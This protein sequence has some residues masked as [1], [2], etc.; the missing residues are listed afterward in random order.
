MKW[1]TRERPKI[2]RIACPWLVTRFID[3]EAEFI[4][5]PKDKVMT[6]AERLGAIPFDV[7]GVEL[8][9]HGPL[10]SFDAFIKKYGLNDPALDRLALIVRGADTGAPDL[11]PEVA[12]LVA[13]SWGLNYNYQD[14]HELLAQ[15]MVMYDALYAWCSRSPSQNA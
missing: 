3:P 10:C 6:E 4:Y 8:G 1:I 14:D 15:G 7:P 5:V 12:G 13:L 2:D 9:H 11:A